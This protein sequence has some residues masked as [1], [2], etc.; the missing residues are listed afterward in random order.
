MSV[1]FDNEVHVNVCTSS[2]KL[3]DLLLGMLR[4][5]ACV[6]CIVL[7]AERTD[8]VSFSKDRCDQLLILDMDNTELPEAMPQ[9]TADEGLI[10]IS[11]DAG[12]TIRSYR[13]HPAAFLKPDFDFGKL[14]NALSACERYLRCGQLG[15]VSPYRRRTFRLPL[16]RIRYI[17]ADAHYCLFN[18]GRAKIRLRF[19]IDEVAKM[20]PNPPFIRIHRS[21]IVNL[22]S[23]TDMS[24][25]TVML[26]GGVSLPLGRTYVQSL[27]AG[28]KQWQKG[29]IFG[30]QPQFDIVN[31]TYSDHPSIS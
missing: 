9:R 12:R 6:E 17:E 13:W 7:S 16:G 14:Q 28:I 24:Y 15:L 31:K 8:K 30:S 29:D 22:G 23:V 18:Q 2:D 10:V 26:R 4:R 19:S 1:A 5:W 20:L 27:R 11:G 25:T 3:A 21:Y